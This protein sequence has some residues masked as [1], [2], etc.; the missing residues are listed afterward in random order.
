MIHIE[1]LRSGN[2]VFWKPGI[3]GTDILIQ[4][5][6]TSLLPGRAGYIPSHLEHRAEPFDDELVTTEIPSAKLEELEPIP[7][8]EAFMDKLVT[9]LQYPEWIKCVHELQNW[10]YWGHEKKELEIND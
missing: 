8:T 6:I 7:L 9:R 4:V 5:E 1:E 2:R 10:Y 3:T